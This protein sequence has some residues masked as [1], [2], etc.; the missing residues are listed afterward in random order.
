MSMSGDDD[1][2]TKK[3]IRRAEK[4]RE[5]SKTRDA[6]KDKDRDG[7][8]GGKDEGEQ[9]S[10]GGKMVGKPL[11]GRGG[12][13]TEAGGAGRKSNKNPH[14]DATKARADLGFRVR[15]EFEPRVTAFP[16]KEGEAWVD[17]PSFLNLQVRIKFLLCGL[18]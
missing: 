11:D 13:A 6:G 16:A 12:G 7:K 5:E 18:G 17:P 1:D 10:R 4:E 3:K 8:D 15:A 9:S 2:E 14:R